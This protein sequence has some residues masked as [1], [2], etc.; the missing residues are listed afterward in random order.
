MNTFELHSQVNKILK[1]GYSTLQILKLLERYA[2]YHIRKQ[3][4]ESLILSKLDYC[5]ILFKTLLQYQK[6][7]WRNFYNPVQVLLNA[8]TDEKMMLQIL[9]GYC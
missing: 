6:I 3:L 8:N 7:D 1:D 4:C 2:P 5:N 9:N